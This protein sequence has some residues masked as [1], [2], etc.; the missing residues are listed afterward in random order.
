MSPAASPPAA[1]AV[2]NHLHRLAAPSGSGPLRRGHHPA[3]PCPSAVDTA[4]EL[5]RRASTGPKAPA[6]RGERGTRPLT[7]Q[8]QNSLNLTSRSDLMLNTS[9][10]EDPG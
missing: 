2:A 8:R 9:H 5:C 10:T 6:E 1:V 4:V 7:R 3:G